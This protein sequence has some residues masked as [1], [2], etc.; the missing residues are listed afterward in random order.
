MDGIVAFFNQSKLIVCIVAFSTRN[1]NPKFGI[2]TTFICIQC[3]STQINKRN[4]NPVKVYGLLKT[5]KLERELDH[6]RKCY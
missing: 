1:G 3:E 5:E 2:N 6:K 4:W